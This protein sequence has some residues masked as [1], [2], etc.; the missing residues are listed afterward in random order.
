[1]ERPSTAPENDITQEPY[2]GP[3]RFVTAM[4]E[5]AAI[6]YATGTGG[7]I[8]GG[9][10][11]GFFYKKVSA[12][13]QSFA[14]FFEKNRHST[15]L[16]KKI[17]ANCAGFA[18]FVAHKSVEHLPGRER[19]FSRIPKE[20]L[21]AVIFAGGLAGFVGFFVVPIFSAFSG[22]KHANEGKRQF[23]RAKE[24]I[25]ATREEL[26]AVREQ[27]ARTKMELDDLKVGAGDSSV[28]ITPDATPTPQP[29]IDHPASLAQIAPDSPTE[30]TAPK[31]EAPVI[32]PAPTTGRVLPRE[33][34]DSPNVIS[35]PTIK[36][37]VLGPEHAEHAAKREHRK[38][39]KDW[40]QHVQESTAA[41]APALTH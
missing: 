25:L 17:P 36:E 4:G 7:L 14:S 30:I 24:E 37:P 26:D 22:V 10:A 35:K 13:E 39:D 16:F 15:N 27:Y 8:G 19:I 38:G 18:R 41:H 28:K 40:A 21:E 9:I 11:G 3:G 20:R 29:V 6:H 33:E 23:S 32:G 2:K 34:M 5:G 31:I 12:I 1:M